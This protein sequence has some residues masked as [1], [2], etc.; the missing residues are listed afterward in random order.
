MSWDKITTEKLLEPPLYRSDFLEI[1]DKFSKTTDFESDVK[2]FDEWTR[3][4][5]QEG[6][7]ST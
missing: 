1:I 4:H 5:G 7:Y 6:E 2:L 3:S